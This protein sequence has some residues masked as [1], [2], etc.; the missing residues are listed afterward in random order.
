MAVRY[1]MEQDMKTGIPFLVGECEVGRGETRLETPQEVNDYVYREMR[2]PMMA[3]EHVCM[4][5]FDIHMDVRGIFEL[6]HGC[7]NAA[8]LTPRMVFSRA[9]L[10]GSYCYLGVVLVHNHPS[11][12]V[13]PSSE[14]R[15]I[16]RRIRE[17]GVLL[18]IEL[19]DFM[20]VGGCKYY[21]FREHSDFGDA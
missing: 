7:I 17:A 6:S 1:V 8:M 3:E 20:I 13:S 21:S 18:R 2:L 16:A 5:S 15:E 19:Q 9:L 4:L 11:G 10:A 14:D 12:D